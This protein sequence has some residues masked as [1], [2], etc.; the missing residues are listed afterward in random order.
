MQKTTGRYWVNCKRCRD[1]HTAARR[2]R[3]AQE[4][5]DD[6]FIDYDYFDYVEG[7]YREL[8][9]ETEYR[10][11]STAQFAGSRP[12]LEPETRVVQH[13][14][15][16]IKKEPRLGNETHVTVKKER[17]K[18][19]SG[20]DVAQEEWYDALEEPKLSLRECSVCGDSSPVQDYP[21]L[22]A[23]EHIPD[24]C[25]ECFIQWLDQQMQ[26]SERASC[27]SSG[28]TNAITHDDVQR[29]A[30]REM[31]TRF[32]ELSMRRLLGEEPGF[33]YCLAKGC[34]SGQ[35]HDTGVEGPI[36]RCAACDFRMCTAHPTP[37]PFHEHESC[38]QYI[39]RIEDEASNTR[40]KREDDASA[41]EVGI[42]DAGSNSATSVAHLIKV[43]KASTSLGTQRISVTAVIIHLGSLATLEIA[44]RVSERRLAFV[45]V[46]AFKLARKRSKPD[47]SYGMM[48]A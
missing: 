40:K 4:A 5:F 16:A 38:A 18:D 33:M 25:Q 3:R 9:Q 42:S 21:S 30:S 8:S 44:D 14:S 23:C 10:Y 43:L 24:V 2:K 7:R 15:A 6:E 48:A 22:M 32:D 20:P 47:S 17:E 26:G 46:E 39:K 37:V 28:C 1:E 29:Y 45:C 27:P 19:V 11:P 31:Y 13:P 34:T 36:F 35:I 41:A 12:Q